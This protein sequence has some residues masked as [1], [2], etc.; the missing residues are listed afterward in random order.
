MRK[1]GVVLEDD[2][3]GALVRRQP[4][5]DLVADDDPSLG[6]GD[7]AGD[8]AQQ[9]GLAA[10]GRAEQCDDF[11]ALYVEIDVFD[12]D[13]ATGIAVRDRIQYERT[14]ALCFSHGAFLPTLVGKQIPCLRYRHFRGVRAFLLHDD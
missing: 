6:L 3:D 4:V 1:Q 7:E 13:R 10:A 2:A 11:A 12:R 14:T 9:R 5:D 8:D